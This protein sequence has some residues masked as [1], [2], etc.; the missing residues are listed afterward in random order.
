MED[1]G[2]LREL[3]RFGALDSREKSEDRARVRPKPRQ[4]S[5]LGETPEHCARRVD[6]ILRT[7]GSHPRV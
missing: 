5:D 4:G 1:H 6:F 7:R 2:A 3:I